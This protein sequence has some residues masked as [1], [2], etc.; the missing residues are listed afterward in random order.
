MGQLKDILY[1]AKTVLKINW[2]VETPCHEYMEVARSRLWV[3]ANG[4]LPKCC[5]F[6]FLPIRVQISRKTVQN[7]PVFCR[8]VNEVSNNRSKFFV[9]RGTTLFFII[10]AL[11]IFPNSARLF[12]ELRI[13][14][15]FCFHTDSD[16]QWPWKKWLVAQT[17][18]LYWSCKE[19]SLLGGYN[20]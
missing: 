9:S 8:C 20:T 3:P 10:S 4:K 12:L 13:K 17:E 2:P 19:C 5:L 7:H 6:V 18:I 1:L 14:I 16:R 15:C 11:L